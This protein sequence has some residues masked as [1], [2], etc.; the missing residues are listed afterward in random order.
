MYFTYL[1][2]HSNKRNRIKKIEYK[3]DIYSDVEK[4]PADPRVESFLKRFI[5]CILII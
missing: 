4:I 2:K 3:D 1:C 5:T